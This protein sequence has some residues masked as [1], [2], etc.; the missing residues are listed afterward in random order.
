ME[1]I[2]TKERNWNDLMEKH[3]RNSWLHKLYILSLLTDNQ[4]DVKPA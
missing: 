1:R 2:L 4:E 3:K